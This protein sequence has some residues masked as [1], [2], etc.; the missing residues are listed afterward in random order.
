MIVAENRWST[1]IL[2]MKFGRA[3]A[4]NPPMLDALDKALQEARKDPCRSVVLTGYDRY[5]SAGLDLVELSKYDRPQ[6]RAFV[7]RFTDVFKNIFFYPKTLVAAVNGHAVAGGCI[8]AMATDYTV[9]RRGDYRI[10]LNEL[11]LGISFPA[12]ASEIAR[13]GLTQRAYAELFS[14]PR[15]CSPEEALEFGLVDQL[16]EE[17]EELIS[18]A[19]EACQGIESGPSFPKGDVKISIRRESVQT[20]WAEREKSNSEF[21]E[22]WFAPETRARIKNLLESMQKRKPASSTAEAPED[23]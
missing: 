17:E 15:V 14:K 16:V 20:I 23:R 11:A 10:G 2:R 21:V 7:E 13:F 6:M 4:I 12:V 3:N 18:E 19:V 9:A 22:S 1:R 5:F 8:L